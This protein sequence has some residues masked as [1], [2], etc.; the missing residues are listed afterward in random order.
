MS[1]LFQKRDPAQLA[2]QLA[3]MNTKSFNEA[4]GKEWKL[5]QDTAGNGSAVI[6]FLPGRTPESM[7]FIKLINHGF[8]IGSKWYI[9]NCTSTHGKFEDCPVC[10]HIQSNDLYNTDNAMYGKLKRKSS[11][12]ANV[13]IIKDPANP[14]ND[15][16]VFKFR[17]GQ[18]IMNMINSQIEVDTSIGEVPVDVFCPIEGANFILKVKKVGGFANYED[19]RFQKQ[20]KIVNI[21]DPAYQK[22]LVDGMV[23][24]DAMI[25]PDQFKSLEKNT[26]T[27]N[28]I[29]GTAVLGGDASD[30]SKQA[31]AL[32]SELDKFGADMA[33]F[34]TAQTTAPAATSTSDAID[35][36]SLL[37]EG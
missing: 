1:A 7:P 4:D 19:S 35:I 3:A 22:E 11:F 20:T 27:F 14:E 29:M 12:W 2:A 8:K 26:E 32:E 37:G 5:T 30:A 36:D 33:D 28:R 23:D 13:L 17:F 9:E 24:L 6:R 34:E 25:A 16:K 10:A 18:K 31:D 21:D 15:G